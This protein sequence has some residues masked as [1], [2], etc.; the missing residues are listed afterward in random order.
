[1]I[2][3]RLEICTAFSENPATEVFSWRRVV[4][5][6]ISVCIRSICLI[7]GIPLQFGGLSMIQFP[8]SEYYQQK[9]N[10]EADKISK[11]LAPGLIITWK[12]CAELFVHHKM[13]FP[14][15]NQTPSFFIGNLEGYSYNFAKNHFPTTTFCVLHIIKICS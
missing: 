5:A 3:A 9:K 13:D 6:D 10:Y 15:K 12:T 8:D 14:L 7:R 11:I 2:E 1:M 4:W